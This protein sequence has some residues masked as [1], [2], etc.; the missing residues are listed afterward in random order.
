M[1]G[2]GEEGLLLKGEVL[3]NHNPIGR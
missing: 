1:G 2:G 3:A